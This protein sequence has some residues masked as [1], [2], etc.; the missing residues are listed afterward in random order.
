VRVSAQLGEAP[1]RVSAEGPVSLEME[2]VLEQGPDAA[3]AP[4]AQRVLEVN[5]QHPVF[6]KLVA[7]ESAGD[8]DKLALY[9]SLLYDQALLVEGL[10]V[11]D[12]VEFAK[13]I[14]ELM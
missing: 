7:A 10:P 9:A 3:Q 1:A 14:C 12:P 6:D 13:N 2:R 11:D 4:K 5:A 8:K